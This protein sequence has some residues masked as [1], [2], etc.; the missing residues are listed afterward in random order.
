MSPRDARRPQMTAGD[1]LRIATF[2]LHFI[3]A[4]FLLA[5][6]FRCGGSL[7]TKTFSETVTDRTGYAVDMSPTCDDPFSSAC[8]YGLPQAYDAVQHGL[9]WNVLALLAA[10]EW[11]SASFALT[12]L[13]DSLQLWWAVPQ[14]GTTAAATAWNA[15]GVLIFM[16]YSM[17]LSTLQAGITALALLA[18]TA[19]QLTVD[20]PI[21]TPHCEEKAAQTQGFIVP[22]CLTRRPVPDQASTTPT[23]TESTRRVIQHYTEYCTSASLLFLAV[24]ILFVP[25]PVSWAPLFGFTGILVCNATGIGAHNCKVDWA[26]TDATPWY[27]LDWNKCGNH[28]KLFMLHSWLS[29]VSS[30]CI[31]LYLA[32]DSLTSPDV[33]VWV[34][35]ILGNL[36][37]TY[38]L[39]GV[40]ATVCYT[41]AGGRDDEARFDRWM[42]RLD[43]GLTILS[44]AAKLPVAYT[45]FYGLT[46]EPGG[47]VCDR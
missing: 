10:F 13:G 1:A 2:L 41:A 23:R 24:L 33:P 5:I 29:L 46:Q 21:P 14:V 37:A 12:Y 19:S 25:D 34:R 11:L 28:F 4:V 20:I 17:P 26:V 16:P 44:A 42:A 47:S 22:G 40:W 3:S 6:T 32:R 27:D 43:Y 39:F 36:L 18:A 9:E 38:T 15:V 35:F 8:F 30:I 31:I 7:I 45:V